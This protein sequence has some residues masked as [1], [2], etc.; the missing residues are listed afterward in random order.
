MMELTI[1]PKNKADL[2]MIKKVLKALNIKFVEND[3]VL[4]LVAEYN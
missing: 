2:V 3:A 1:K 4:G